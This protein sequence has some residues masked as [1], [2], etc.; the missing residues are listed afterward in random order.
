MYLHLTRATLRVTLRHSRLDNA[1]LG[2]DY[3]FFD[4]RPFLQAI[5][6]TAIPDRLHRAQ[7]EGTG[8]TRRGQN[9]LRPRTC[10]CGI[11]SRRRS[12]FARD[13]AADATG[14]PTIVV[15]DHT[16]A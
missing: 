8:R 10:D 7:F 2:V 9:R 12:P 15:R 16:C 13:R 11:W 1:A 3:S 4:E 5:S 14:L 6:Q